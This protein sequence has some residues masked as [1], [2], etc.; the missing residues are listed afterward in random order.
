MAR[1]PGLFQRDGVYYVRVMV[2][3]DLRKEYGTTKR[4]VSLRTSD[5]R[6]A[7]VKATTLR[8]ERRVQGRAVA[9]ACDHGFSINS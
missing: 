1:L 8:A 7:K 4:V 2:P 9:L 5:S 6:T 3:L